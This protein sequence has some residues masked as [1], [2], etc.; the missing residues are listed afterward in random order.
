[1]K[2]GVLIRCSRGAAWL[3]LP[4]VTSVKADE[5][6]EKKTREMIVAWPVQV[7]TAGQTELCRGS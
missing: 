3:H 5:G 2:V 6:E 4:G 7:Q 1:M